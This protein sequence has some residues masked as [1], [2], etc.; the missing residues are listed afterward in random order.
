MSTPSVSEYIQRLGKQVKDHQKFLG[1]YDELY[2]FYNDKLPQNKHII[3]LEENPYTDPLTRYP[4]ETVH[5]FSASPF[6]LSLLTPAIRIFKVFTKTEKRVL[7]PFENKM[8]FESFKDPIKYLDRQTSFVTERWMGPVVG[9]TKLDIKYDGLAGKGATP[10]TLN[11]VTVNLTIECQD[12]KMLYKNLGTEDN[13][14][15]Y[16]D[17]FAQPSKNNNYAIN[18]V[19]GYDAP[20]NMPKLQKFVRKQLSLNLYPNAGA[21]QITYRAN[22]TAMLTTTLFGKSEY[23]SEAI[24]LLNPKY[25]KNIKKEKNMILVQ[26]EGEYDATELDKKL[27]ALDELKEKIERDQKQKTKISNESENAKPDKKPDENKTG[28]STARVKKLE[29]DVAALQR[30]AQL[31]NAAGAVPSVFPFITV[32]YELGKIYY[33][34]LDNKRYANYIQKIAGDEPVDTSDIKKVVPD[35]KP[36]EKETEE[37]IVEAAKKPA[38]GEK[39]YSVGSLT[40]RNFDKENKARSGFEKIKYFYFGDLLDVILNNSNGGGAGQD[41]EALGNNAY[42]FLLGPAVYVKNAKTKKIYN[43]ANVPISLDMFLFQLNKFIVNGKAKKLELRYFVSSF[44]KT[45]FDLAV[46]GGEKQKTG[47]DQ[48][49]YDAKSVYTVDKDELD[50]TTNFIDN[51]EK[52]NPTLG[53]TKLQ[54]LVVIKSILLDKNISKKNKKKQNVP[55]IYLGGP[56]KGP[57]QDISFKTHAIKGFAERTLTRQMSLNKGT[58]NTLGETADDSVFISSLV[59]SDLKLVGNPYL[60]IS[61]RVF[62]DSRFVD[63]GFWQEKNNLIFFTGYFSVVK[64]QHDI[65][66]N[67]WS[68][69]YSLVYDGKLKT[70]TFNAF[71]GPLP[72]S[73]N[74]ALIRETAGSTAPSPPP[75]LSTPSEAKGGSG[76]GTVTSPSKPVGPITSEKEKK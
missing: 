64:V 10:S 7:I 33:L 16:K 67:I 52:L 55:T 69:S 29:K 42:K 24:D 44:M 36:K 34:E 38:S 63:G 17:I 37:D 54:D 11:Y 66:A 30:K 14:V 41:L 59:T 27:G 46:F 15:F 23:L 61:D 20:D 19:I 58:E 43:M 4:P 6:D 73:Q 40:V 48:Q 26:K 60:N 49:Y 70:P 71:K 3:Y 9:L 65:S 8:D 56:D 45:F 75:E 18:I 53:T 21:T 35:K 28:D 57:L 51:L 1:Y 47:K 12:V 13:K 72:A 76:S 22:G 68:T 39:E 25:Y 50:K 62:V 2:E 5:F 74:A 31:A 32:L